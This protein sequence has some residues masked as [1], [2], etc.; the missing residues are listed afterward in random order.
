LRRPFDQADLQATWA[1]ARAALGPEAYAA[2]W[3]KGRAMSLDQAVESAS[4][5]AWLRP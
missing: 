4:R 2:A 5:G 3:G 1:A